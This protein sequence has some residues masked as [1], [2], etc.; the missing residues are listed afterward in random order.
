MV[1]GTMSQSAPHPRAI[2]LVEI[3]VVFGVIGILVGL[4]VPGV[5]M[6]Q[7]NS[8]ATVSQSNL[9]QWGTSMTMYAN[10]RKGRLPWEGK[11]GSGGME[12]NLA[13]PTQAATSTVTERMTASI[14]ALS[15]VDGAPA[16]SKR[17]G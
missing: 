2:T 12:T 15:S 9:R 1:S 4:V 3:L 6:V 8:R 11:K 16:R 14:S 7:K 13:E 5:M 17:T 10:Q